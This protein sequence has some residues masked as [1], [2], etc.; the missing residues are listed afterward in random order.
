MATESES[1]AFTGL[2]VILAFPFNGGVVLVGFLQILQDVNVGSKVEHVL[3][4][5]T[6]R[7]SYEALKPI[8]RGSH[9]ITYGTSLINIST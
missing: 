2:H 6:A 4:A 8:D 9:H 1:L 7:Q 3:F 5:A